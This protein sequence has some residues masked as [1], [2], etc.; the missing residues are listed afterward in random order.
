MELDRE[1]ENWA[2][3]KAT[4]F[5]IPTMIQLFLLTEKKNPMLLQVFDTLVTSEKFTLDN[6]GQ[7]SHHFHGII[8]F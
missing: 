3:D 7:R 6:S 8:N 2:I 5:A 1:G 4:M